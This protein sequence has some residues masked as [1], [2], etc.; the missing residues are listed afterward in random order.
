M[1][2][3]DEFIECLGNNTKVVCSKAHGFGTD[4]I[5][6]GNF[7]GCKKNDTACDL[8]TGCGIIPLLWCSNN[9]GKDITGVDI[10]PKAISQFSKGIQLSNLQNKA[11]A[12]NSDLKDLKGKL[13]FGRFNL[14]TMNPPYKRANT[15][16]LSDL[17][18]EQI[19]RHELMCDIDDICNCA[20]KLLQFGGRFCVCNRPERLCD[21]MFAMRKANLEPKRIRFVSK[22]SKSK[23]WLFLIEGKKGSKP[24]LTIIPQLNIQ[25]DNGNDSQELIEILGKYREK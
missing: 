4:A 19:A 12:I 24:H 22:N 25:D 9:L 5:L 13:E 18:A 21:V 11:K 17:T 3:E 10:Q 2:L 23:P 20:T 6:L 8:G 14:V 7:A 16:I 15:G 1:L